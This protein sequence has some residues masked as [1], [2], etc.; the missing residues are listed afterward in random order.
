MASSFPTPPPS[1]IE[2][3]AEKVYQDQ[4]THKADPWEE[5][6]DRRRSQLDPELLATASKLVER[7]LAKVVADEC[8]RIP[9]DEV[10]VHC[11]VLYCTALHCTA[12]H[13]TALYCTV[14]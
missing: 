4:F 10:R 3:R 11:T 13:C 9:I 5:E 8:L 2:G 14:L 7:V 6:C 12:L 1:R